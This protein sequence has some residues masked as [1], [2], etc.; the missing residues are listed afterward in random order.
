[1]VELSNVADQ[2]S[3]LGA[4]TEKYSYVSWLVPFSALNFSN[5]DEYW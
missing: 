5:R 3:G 2:A 4:S 1:M